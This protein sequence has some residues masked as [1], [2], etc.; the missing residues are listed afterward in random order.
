MHEEW[1]MKEEIYELG[2]GD[3]GGEGDKGGKRD[4]VGEE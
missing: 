2:E 4:E 1:E 3:E